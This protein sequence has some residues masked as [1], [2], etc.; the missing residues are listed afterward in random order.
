MESLY[1]KKNAMEIPKKAFLKAPKKR[2]NF[3][4]VGSKAACHTFL[5]LMTQQCQYCKNM[6]EFRTRK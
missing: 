4:H 2:I 5:R 1:Q 3:D 6:I